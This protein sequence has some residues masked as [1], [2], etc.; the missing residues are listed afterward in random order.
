MPHSSAHARRTSS[1]RAAWIALAL[2]TALNLLNYSD[3]YILAGVQPLV[4]RA[5]HLNDERIGALTSAFFI[6]YML[7]APLTGWLGDRLPRKPLIM[8][9]ALLWSL[10]TLAT[11]MVHT[12]NELYLRHALVGVGE[13]SFGIFAPA[14]LS[15]YWPP[16]QRNRILTIFYLSLPVGAAMGYIVGGTLGQFYGWRMPF[17]ASAVPG[18]LIVVFVGIWMREPARGAS[19]PS[20]AEPARYRVTL[21][22]LTQNPAYW[23]AT[24]GMAMMVFSMGGISVW[25]PTFLVRQGHYSLA[26]ASQMLGGITVVDGIVGTWM[27]GWLAQRWLKR[28]HA[29]LYLLSAWSMLLASPFALMTFF[30]PRSAIVPSLAVA[31][32]CLFLNTG[33]LNAAIINSVSAPIRATAIAIELFTIHALGDAPSPR[34]IGWVSDRSSL[35]MGLAVTL[36]TLLVSGALLFAGARFAPPMDVAA[37]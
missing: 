3:R 14:L 7:A 33:P 30:G 28:N 22:A 19:E 13:A 23:T 37:V 16:E 21:T 2:L 35:Q 34:V 36:I 18:L 25:M 8:A 15:D 26:G 29:A 1:A 20:Q 9:G 24:V 6:A 27:G 10:L 5:F 17:Y 12:Y 11:A 31:E 4:Q 32:F